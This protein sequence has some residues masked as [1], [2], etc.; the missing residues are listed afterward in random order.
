MDFL[1]EMFPQFEEAVIRAVLDQS[2]GNVEE[3][4]AV[5]LSPG[6]EAEAQQ[7]PVVSVPL[8][9]ARPPVEKKRRFEEDWAVRS[10]LCSSQIIIPSFPPSI[11]AIQALARFTTSPHHLT[12]IFSYFELTKERNEAYK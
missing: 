2:D 11:L 6:F 8:Q 9:P 5:L 12:T 4:S 3:A 10:N 7:K 1:K